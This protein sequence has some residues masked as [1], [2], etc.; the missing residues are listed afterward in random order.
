MPTDPST[1]AFSPFESVAHALLLVSLG[2]L[3]WVV[4]KGNRLMVS[5]P[6]QVRWH[7]RHNLLHSFLAGR[8]AT[9]A[10]Q[11]SWIP[12]GYFRAYG[13]F[14]VMGQWIGCAVGSFG[15]AC[16]AIAIAQN[17]LN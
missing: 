3:F 5:H 8:S 9:V 15:L 11:R 14:G 10:E 12:D 17:F 6:D 13:F 1:L 16:I 7:A 2:V 4:G